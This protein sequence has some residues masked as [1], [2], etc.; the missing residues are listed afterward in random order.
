[1]DYKRIYAEFIADRRLKEP[2]LAGYVE[3]HHIA[4]RSLGGS[5]DAD[6]LIRLTASDHFFAH[7]LLAKIHGGAMWYAVN[8]MSL[9][10][11]TGDRA[12]DRRYVLRSRRW[13]EVAKREFGAAH[14]KRMKGAYTG[15]AHPMFGKPCSPIALEKLR[16]RQAAGFHPMQT[17]AAREKVRAA[18][19]G[20]EMSPE[21]RE[22]IAAS[23]RG[24]PLSAETRANMSKGQTGKKRSAEAVAKVAAANTGKKRTPEQVEAMRARLTGRKLSPEHRASLRAAKYVRVGMAGKQHTPEAKARYTAICAARRIYAEQHGGNKRTI[25]LAMMREA[26]INI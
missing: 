24:K 4:P 3:K 16:A 2:A 8:A 17:E 18:M 13:Y 26:G 11:G 23:R 10:Q 19:L 1:M 12:Q 15:E 6:N 7:L 5:D 25:T 22:K 21:W 9:C 20:R 14:S